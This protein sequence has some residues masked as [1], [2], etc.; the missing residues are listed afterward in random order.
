[1][2]K[3]GSVDTG[4]INTPL[5]SFDCIIDTD[6]GLLSL[7]DK[8][9]LDSSI[10]DI[11]FFNNNHIIKNMVR[12]LYKRELKNPLSICVKDKD[13]DI[14]SLYAEFMSSKYKEILEKSMVT[15]IYNLLEQFKLSGD[16]KGS[17]VCYSQDEVDCLKELPLFKQYPIY[18]LEEVDIDNY[19]QFFFRYIDDKY[20]NHMSKY[21]KNKSIYIMN[22][23]FNGTPYEGILPSD[24]TKLLFDNRNRLYMMDMYNEEKLK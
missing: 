8:D 21:I 9:Y 1:M 7:I 16:V 6:F 18:L 12:E 24:S 4:G 17:V 19:N 3:P 23:K 2:L 10:F 22:H 20:I 14:D 5:V 11:E 13:Y 15:E